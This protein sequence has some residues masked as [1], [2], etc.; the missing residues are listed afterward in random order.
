MNCTEEVHANDFVACSVRAGHKHW[1]AWLL[2]IPAFLKVRF[3]GQPLVVL[4]FSCAGTAE[5][6]VVRAERQSQASLA[7]GEKP[8]RIT[9]LCCLIEGRIERP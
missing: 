4:L 9:S 3:L 2:V 8:D 7:A 5:L 1:A 6:F